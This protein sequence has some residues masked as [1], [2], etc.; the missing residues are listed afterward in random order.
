LRASELSSVQSTADDLSRQVQS[1][2][3]QIAVQNDPALANLPLDGDAEAST[4]DIIT[5]HLLEFRSIR[6]LQEQNVKLLKLTRGLMAKLDSQEISR[7]TADDGDIQVGLTLDQATETIEKLHHQLLDAQRKINEVI[8]ER[9]TLS[10]LLVRGE[11][12]RK[13]AQVGG[14]GLGESG[15]DAQ[16]ALVQRLQEEMADERRKADEEVER[17]RKELGA[18][19]EE[20]GTAEVGRAQAEAKATLLKGSFRC[21]SNCKK[22]TFQS[23][24]PWPTTRRLSRRRNTPAWSLGI[25]KSRLPSTKPTMIADRLI[26]R[27]LFDSRLIDR[28]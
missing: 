6:S 26:Y 20:L 7:A 19:K 2:V 11:G 24:S 14:N 9:D 3:R 27:F 15:S 17:V 1:L 12:L 16:E 18:R 22:L 28:L 4:G 23:N 5:D 25:A 21:M 13:P 10:K 8:R